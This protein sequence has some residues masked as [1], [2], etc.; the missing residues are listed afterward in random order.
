MLPFLSRLCIFRDHLNAAQPLKLKNTELDSGKPITSSC[1]QQTAQHKTTAR[2]SL[3][4]TQHERQQGGQEALESTRGHTFLWTTEEVEL[5]VLSSLCI[6]TSSGLL[7]SR[8]SCMLLTLLLWL[9]VLTDMLGMEWLL[10]RLSIFLLRFDPCSLSY[11]TRSMGYGYRR[12]S[13][14]QRVTAVPKVCFKGN[15]AELKGFCSVF[16]QL[17]FFRLP[18]L[19]STSQGAVSFCLLP[20][21][22]HKSDIRTVFLHV[23]VSLGMAL[24]WTGGIQEY[25]MGGERSLINVKGTIFEV[26]VKTMFQV[27]IRYNTFCESEDEPIRS[28]LGSYLRYITGAEVLT[29]LSQ[30]VSSDILSS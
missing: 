26:C 5:I 19:C 9:P 7:S 13:P 28:W 4:P 27:Y 24:A 2:R 1:S 30:A 3:G 16:W 15:S 21:N 23:S 18:G 11:K 20:C 22:P 14:A 6:M 12:R 17:R 25:W 10:P 8:T 29:S